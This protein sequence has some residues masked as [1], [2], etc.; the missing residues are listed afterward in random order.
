MN[1]LI[2]LLKA[3]QGAIKL[4]RKEDAHNYIQTVIDEQQGKLLVPVEVLDGLIDVINTLKSNGVVVTY[5][6]SSESA[7]EAVKLL[8]EAT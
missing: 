1:V 4:D 8:E 3:A 7:E 6:V 2:D 5:K